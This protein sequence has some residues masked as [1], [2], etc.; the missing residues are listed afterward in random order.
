MGRLEQFRKRRWQRASEF[1]GWLS[2]S[3]LPYLSAE[4]ALTLYWAFGGTRAAEFRTNPIEEIRDSLDF[5][6]YDTVKLEG[7][8]QE[9][10]SDG[11]AYKL[12]G[13]GKEFIS[14]LACLGDPTLFAAWNSSAE[15]ALKLLGTYPDTLRTGPL[16]LC[17]LDLLEALAR[18]R[19]Q[20]G[21]ADFRTV[22][23][24]S[25]AVS[26]LGKGHRIMSISDRK[27]VSQPQPSRR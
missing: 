22:G 13:A 20:L 17:Y 12:A 11:G 18:V 8:F 4:Q 27:V 21:L 19:Q 26:R 16:G 7:R 24:F 1:I 14:Y 5:L 23:E 2:P 9:C 3:T 15:R 25:Y 6:L 10:A